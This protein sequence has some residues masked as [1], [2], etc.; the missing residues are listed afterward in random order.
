MDFEAII[1]LLNQMGKEPKAQ[2]DGSYM[3]LCPAH[4][5]T[6]QSLH[7]FVGKDGG[8]GFKCYAGC[9]YHDI[10]D[11][12]GVSH[13]D[14]NPGMQ[15]AVSKKDRPPP[16]VKKSPPT[17]P[18]FTHYP[19]HN[20]DGIELGIVC[21]EDVGPKKKKFTQWSKVEGGYI[22][23]TR[24][25]HGSKWLS[26]RPLY[27]LP[28][29]LANDGP[30]VVL[31]GEKC[32]HAVLRA[33]PKQ[34]PTTWPGGSETWNYADW[35]SIEGRTVLLISDQD[36]GGR[37][38]M[39][40]VADRLVKLGCEVYLCLAE[41]DDKKD[42][43]DWLEK[44]KGYAK[45]MIKKLKKRHR[46]KDQVDKTTIYDNKYY[47]VMGIT[48][49]RPAIYLKDAGWIHTVSRENI[50]K[51]NFLISLSVP[52]AFLAAA[53]GS[54]DEKLSVEG[55]L[56]IGESILRKADNLGPVD[57]RSIYGVGAAKLSDGQ[58]VWHLGDKLLIDGK[59]KPLEMPNKIW[60]KEPPI[61]LVE[62][63]T[64]EEVNALRTA[65]MDYRWSSPMDGERFLGWIVASLIGGALDWRP[66]LFLVARAS[67]GKSWL[68]TDV[69]Q[70]LLGD[71]LTPLSDATPAGIA[72]EM[73]N[74]STP[75]TIDEANMNSG[76]V[77]DV[78]KQLRVSSGGGSKRIRAD[79][80]GSGVQTFEPRFSALLSDTSIPKMEDA[81]ASRIAIVSLGEEVEDWP[82]VRDA[83]I[84]AMTKGPRILSRIIRETPKIVSMVD[85]IAYRLTDMEQSLSTREALITAALT[86]GN[87]WWC[88]EYDTENITPLETVYPNTTKAESPEEVEALITL[89]DLTFRDNISGTDITISQGLKRRAFDDT[90]A[91]IFG[92]K[93]DG[94]DLIV[95]PSLPSLRQKLRGTNIEGKEL[96]QHLLQIEGAESTNPLWFG[97][98]RR[99]AIKIPNMV[100][101]ELGI[102]LEP[103]Q[104]DP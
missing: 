87:Q 39:E 97:S 65:I 34:S 82:K 42:V 11:A 2:R 4:P 43:A 103:E 52:Q 61:H 44:G 99:R 83:I 27:R 55:A 69:L 16:P 3:T 104:G 37:K 22:A 25:E 58:I 76:W 78:L 67:S 81:D 91:G 49:G 84:D 50:V 75:V 100:L 30:I 40:G 54:D 29:L 14:L 53:A 15:N 41:G 93:M 32:V 85:K 26:P 12:I 47:R 35:K 18:K 20:K 7:V 89:L 96:R 1:E 66:H 71:V 94:L 8:T 57:T 33:W 13:K 21:R 9:K 70:K 101:K 23:S 19:Y 77:Q 36:E 31:E 98:I 68:L 24:K 88:S 86:A 38:A 5:D 10:L 28:Q 72:R 79:S 73:K 80:T 48:N 60:I 56:R 45:E 90:I 51:K 59:E 92:C 62:D 74:R 102:D 63:A 6:D 95:A 17:G 64:D 46:A